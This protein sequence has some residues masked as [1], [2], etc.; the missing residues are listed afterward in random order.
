MRALSEK[1]LSDYMAQQIADEILSGR[2]VGGTQ[3]KQ[4]ELAEVFGASRIPIRE[5]FQVLEGQGLIV[6]LAT[7]RIYAVELSEEQ[8][9][10]IYE[11]IGDILKKAVENLKNE[12]K[13]KEV[14]TILSSDLSTSKRFDEILLEC[15]DNAYLSKLLYT[16][17]DCY[18][19]FAVSCGSNEQEN[20]CR[21]EMKQIILEEN[22]V[23]LDSISGRKKIFK[24]ID[25][26]MKV[27]SDIVN[28]ERGKNKEHYQ[29]RAILEGA[30]ARLCAAPETD[31]SE[32]EEIYQDS[33]KVLENKDF[34][35][36]T[37]IN[38]EFHNEIWTAAG[39]GKMKNM[40][41]ELWNGLSMGNMVSEE[42]YAKVSV[43]EHGEILEAIKAHDGDA[44]EAAMKE[45]I[46]RS[47][48]DMLTYYN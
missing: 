26:W 11:M 21:E 13:G 17:S 8:I 18:I 22:G 39:N 20:K 30:A 33:C 12:D 5:A 45:H 28:I 40:I 3:L 41:S 1:R 4:E 24:K 38:R 47:R 34:S 42:D 25:V 9:Q 44:A 31:I 2:I 7:R 27:L 6:R 29:L 19:R 36:Y 48:D 46:M 23:N 15:T 14:I 16:A 43:K 10:I 35:R 37:D 32:L